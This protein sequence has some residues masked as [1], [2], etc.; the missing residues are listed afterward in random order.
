M[1]YKHSIFFN[2]LLLFSF[3]VFVT[4]K[5][6][7]PSTTRS[8]CFSSLKTN[9]YNDQNIKEKLV[10]LEKL[11]KITVADFDTSYPLLRDVFHPGMELFESA[12][13]QLK[14]GKFK[15]SF[16][17]GMLFYGPPG[18]GKTTMVKAL[19]NEAHCKLFK[20]S[21]SQLGNQEKGAKIITKTFA[22]AKKIKA[23]KGVIIFIDGLESSAP[24]ITNLIRAEFDDCSE[25]HN[26]ILTV[27]TS[28]DFG[29]INKGFR[30]RFRCIE[31]SYPD[32]DNSYKILKNKTQHLNVPLSETELQYHAKRMK[33]LSGREL[34][35]FIQDV[36]SYIS[37]G[38]NKE[39]AIEL[40]IKK[41][42]RDKEVNNSNLSSVL[43]KF[44]YS[45]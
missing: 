37:D 23:N 14:A 36:S 33:N 40:V 35:N 27:I 20:I 39:N 17:R 43:E 26:N 10:R 13:K 28:S 15:D 34:T 41:Q 16:R 31:F 7:K 3:F 9:H 2:I 29:A 4:V 11:K 19:A 18:V 44:N 30:D 42:K 22:Q 21:I 8:P 45:I 5:G 24:E 12:A 6:S 32:Q 38:M 1:P 25:D